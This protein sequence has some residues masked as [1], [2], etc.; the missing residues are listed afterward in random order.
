MI[1]L[2]GPFLFAPFV[3]FVCASSFAFSIMCISLRAHPVL[4][5]TSVAAKKDVRPRSCGRDVADV[6]VL[7]PERVTAAAIWCTF[8]SCAASQGTATQTAQA[9]LRCCACP[10]GS[11]PASKRCKT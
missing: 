6:A 5:R 1:F 11:G 9:R 4:S 7:L 10:R 3:G 8:A 2:H